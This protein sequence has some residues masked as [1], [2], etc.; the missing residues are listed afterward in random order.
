M[1]SYLYDPISSDACLLDIQNSTW[2]YQRYIGLSG[3]F[4]YPTLPYPALCSPSFFI[5]AVL[6][7]TIFLTL[8]AVE[9]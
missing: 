7:T 1:L 2:Y 9:V 4:S 5:T 6:P 3:L 8:A